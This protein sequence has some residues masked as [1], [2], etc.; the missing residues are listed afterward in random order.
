MDA[1]LTAHELSL[2]VKGP[3][4]RRRVVDRATFSIG[5]GE[6]F[7]LAGESGSGKSLI[8]KSIMRLL[9][10]S[11]VDMEGR[12]ELDGDDLIAASPAHLR[13]LRG[14]RMSMIFQ[15]PMTSLNPLIKVGRQIEEA[16]TAHTAVSASA[17][18]ARVIQLLA[19]V[20]FTDPGGAANLY[21]H[22]LSGGMRQRVMIAIALANQPALL[23]ADEPTTAL[24]VTIQKEVMDILRRLQRDYQLS[25]LFIS[26]DLSLVSQYSDRVGI[27]YGGVL[28]EQGQ[29][30][31][32]IPLPRHPYT[33]ALLKCAPQARIQGQRQT[34]IKGSVP[35]IAD[36]P[37]GCRYA[38]RCAFKQDDCTRDPV[39]LYRDDS[40]RLI[41]CN[42][43]L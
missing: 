31:E 26:H 27:L 25:V 35:S 10:G 30:G 9:P 21:P 40:Q 11:L 18:R 32:V 13:S 22:E 2:Y 24:D 7:A 6:F 41:R 39:H 15:E 37:E 33:A 28:M 29:T 34:G 16:M 42:H 23:I 3:E 14:S 43:P 20:R 5:R 1:L 19:D 12:L 36:W 4:G 8:A 38:P 17:R